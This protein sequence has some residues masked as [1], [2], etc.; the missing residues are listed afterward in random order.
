MRKFI[1][2]LSPQKDPPLIHAVK[3]GKFNTVQYLIQFN[4]ANV[5]EIDSLGNTAMVYAAR[6]GNLE[7]LKLLKSADFDLNVRDDAGD[8][9]LLHAVKFNDFE[10]ILFLLDN[11]AD[12]D[13][14]DTNGNTA[15]MHTVMKG[16][17]NILQI[18]LK[19]APNVRL[20]NNAGQSALTIA[21]EAKQISVVESYYCIRLLANYFPETRIQNEEGI[22]P[23]DLLWNN[24]IENNFVEETTFSLKSGRK[25][26]N[27]S[28]DDHYTPL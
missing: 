14:S 23:M 9:P 1:C 5:K 21:C 26:S 12:I 16:N 3:K 20:L 7:I 8:T 4:G 19:Y 24:D 28:P 2:F 17:Y 27:T 13:A 22:R 10:V 11:G 6:K 15:I 25:S 18:L